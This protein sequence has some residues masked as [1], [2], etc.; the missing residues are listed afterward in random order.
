MKS[1]L[2]NWRARRYLKKNPPTKKNESSKKIIPIKR[3]SFFPSDTNN[4]LSFKDEFF[5]FFAGKESIL[6]I[7][8]NYWKTFN[9]TL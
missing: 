7:K 8:L 9:Y 3:K 4:G 6:C 1:E 2:E 5:W